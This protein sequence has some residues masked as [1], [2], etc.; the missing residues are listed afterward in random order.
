MWEEGK[1]A[2]RVVTQCNCYCDIFGLYPHDPPVCIF[3]SVA[4]RSLAA[5][6]SFYRCVFLHFKIVKFSR[7]T[8]AEGDET[9]EARS[10]ISTDIGREL[11]DFVILTQTD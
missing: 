9:K 6:S 11:D 5:P 1:D 8:R 2:W 3:S 4:S 10:R 7:A